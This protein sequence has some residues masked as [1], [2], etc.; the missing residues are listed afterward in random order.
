MPE[1]ER[2]TPRSRLLC[3]LGAALALLA[4]SASAQSVRGDVREANARPNHFQS[5]KGAVVYVPTKAIVVDAAT[6]ATRKPTAAEVDQLMVTIKPLANQG[7][8]N[9]PTPKANGATSLRLDDSYGTV[10]L[11]RPAADGTFETRCVSTFA[12]A[13]EFLGLKAVAA[14]SPAAKQFLNDGRR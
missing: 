4:T 12:E 9:R 8:G 1:R 5:A 14:D 13:V 6:H 7:K 10:V 2:V 3:C 11:A